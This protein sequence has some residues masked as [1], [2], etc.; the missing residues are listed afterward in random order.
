MATP[1]NA[2]N[3]FIETFTST[4]PDPAKCDITLTVGANTYEFTIY[5]GPDGYFYFNYKPIVSKLVNSSDF[6]DY[7]HYL[8]LDDFNQD[9]EACIFVEVEKVITLE[10][11]ATETVNSDFYAIKALHNVDERKM[12]ISRGDA[13]YCH[14]ANANKETYLTHFLGYPFDFSL[15]GATIE[16]EGFIKVSGEEYLAAWLATPHGMSFTVLNFV[17]TEG[18]HR[19]TLCDGLNESA[20][21]S[22]GE[23]YA[24]IVYND[25][26]IL[27]L[28]VK[29][30][31]GE[32]VYLKWHNQYGGWD[33]WLF[34]KNMIL[35]KDDSLIGTIDNDFT[36]LS[37]SQGARVSM[38]KQSTRRRTL[39]ANGIADYEL[40]AILGITHSP[41]VYMFIGS[42]Y[43]V[44]QP[45]V[46]WV[47]VFVSGGESYST[48]QKRKVV[49][50]QLELQTETL[51]L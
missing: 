33:Y 20:L 10:S 45:F 23:Q 16:L 46:N 19:F 38:G 31:C 49:T 6:E 43:S 26:N 9:E 5:P 2:F 29:A 18:V 30:N 32:G 44:Y 37:T 25:T 40:N 21:L 47:E 1:K 4:G 17:E 22:E 50:V 14:H 39:F 27:K 15:Y 35:Q 8:P 42:P 24:T 51:T 36:N 13:F 3:N 34:D 7:H 12:F 28:N 41:K 48:R 11:T